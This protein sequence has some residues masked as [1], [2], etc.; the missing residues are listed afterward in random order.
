M[1]L[2]TLAILF[3]SLFLINYIVSM[4]MNFLGID[5]QFYGSYLLWVIV[6]LIFWAILPEPIKYFD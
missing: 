5:I 1:K 4:I 2:S 3:V 6:L